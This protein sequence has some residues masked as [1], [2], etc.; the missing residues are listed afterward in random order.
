MDVR[1]QKSGRPD[2]TLQEFA[3]LLQHGG[4]HLTGRDHD[5]GDLR[6]TA[7]IYFILPVLLPDFLSGKKKK[8]AP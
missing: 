4:D 1:S 7:I 6:H 3:R 2:V 8:I 5:R